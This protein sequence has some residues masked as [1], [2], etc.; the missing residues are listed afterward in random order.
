MQRAGTTNEI[1]KAFADAMSKVP[2]SSTATETWSFPREA[3]HT[4]AMSTFGKKKTKTC[5]LFD[6][7]SAE[8]TPVIEAKRAALTKYKQT[9]SKRTLK[10]LRLARSKVQNA[11]SHCANEYWQELSGSI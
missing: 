6:A 10:A 1:S 2:Y 4:T 7:K 3:I 11:V 8:L 9:P 5:D